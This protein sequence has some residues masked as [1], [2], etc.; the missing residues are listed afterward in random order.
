MNWCCQLVGYDALPQT[1]Q[2]TAVL[3]VN[4]ATI[5]YCYGDDDDDAH[6]KSASI[7]AQLSYWLV[8]INNLPRVWATSTCRLLSLDAT[9][10]RLAPLFTAA[11]C[12]SSTLTYLL[13]APAAAV[14]WLRDVIV[15]AA[16]VVTHWSLELAVRLEWT[17]VAYARTP[18]ASIC[19]CTTSCATSPQRTK[20]LQQV[21]STLYIENPR[22][23]RNPRQIEVVEFGP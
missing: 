15:A 10:T 7:D 22:L 18:L 11:L 3:S 2:C 19:C 5:N 12:A 8:R 4:G 16:H 20:S 14:T 23:T 13:T 9:N 17:L 6:C 21:Y 1:S